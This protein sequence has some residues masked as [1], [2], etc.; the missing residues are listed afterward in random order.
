MKKVRLF[1]ALATALA[2]LGVAKAAEVVLQA[3]AAM[4]ADPP[5]AQPKAAPPAQK[6]GARPAAAPA[7]ANCPAPSMAEQAGLSAAE[8]RLLNS[9][10]ER[11][12]QLDARERTITTREGVLKAAEGRVQ[13]RLTELREIESQ[14]KGQL[15]QLDEQE[16]QR[17][18]GLVRVYEKMRPRDSAEIFQGLDDSVQVQVASRMKEGPLAAMMAQMEPDRAR[19]LTTL[20]AQRASR[21][22]LPASAPSGAARAPSGAGAA[23]ARPAAGRP[24]AAAPARPPAARA[25]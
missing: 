7:A 1:P 20:L 2:V 13:A 11:R 23:P 12:Q 16:N 17:I 3:P 15:G 4:A 25:G 22:S 8:F 5:K 14:I 21:P 19:A 9:L 24:A 18:Q 6:A 10:Q